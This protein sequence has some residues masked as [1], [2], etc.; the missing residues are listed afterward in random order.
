VSRHESKTSIATHERA[1][2]A[3]EQNQMAVKAL[4]MMHATH[5]SCHLL[6]LATIFTERLKENEYTRM[7]Q[8]GGVGACTMGL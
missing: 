1:Y 2:T 3:V 5:L 4:G 7:C 6:K 8:S